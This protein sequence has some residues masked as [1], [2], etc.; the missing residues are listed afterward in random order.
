[1]NRD[2]REL[3][4]GHQ[5]LKLQSGERGNK[6][7]WGLLS[8]LCVNGAESVQ[9]GVWMLEPAV[10]RHTAGIHTGIQTV[11]W[12]RSPL[13]G[14]R[15][16]HMSECDLSPLLGLLIYKGPCLLI[17]TSTPMVKHLGVKVNHSRPDVNANNL[18]SDFI[19]R[20][21]VHKS[22]LRTVPPKPTVT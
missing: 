15:C 14:N 12:N 2:S 19:W 7:R 5:Q 16:P 1:M 10:V 22:S 18:R 21:T 6:T 20:S 9:Q 13:F 3:T 4:K 11:I 17:H 8:S